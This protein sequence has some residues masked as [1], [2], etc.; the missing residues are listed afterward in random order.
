MPL[1]APDEAWELTLVWGVEGDEK[2]L[3]IEILIFDTYDGTGCS[4][5]GSNLVSGVIL[6]FDP[7]VEGF[8]RTTVDLKGQGLEMEMP[9]TGRIGIR[10]IHWKDRDARIYSSRT[11]LG[12]WYGKS[13]WEEVIGRPD[14]KGF[15]DAEDPN[16]RLDP[17]DCY[18][19][20]SVCPG[21]EYGPIS[22]AIQ[23]LGEGRTTCL[24]KLKKD[25]KPKRG[26]ESCPKKDDLFSNDR[27]CRNGC[28]CAKKAKV[29][30]VDCPEGGPGVCK[31]L[32]GKRDSCGR[33][34]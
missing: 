29:K 26:C 17:N 21:N 20:E 15:N 24:Y 32:K 7:P 31:K 3:E 25:A 6:G 8:Y 27:D 22:Q 33:L 11:S 34:P 5:S 28:H 14:K 12:L 9:D 18:T 2:P 30:K 23:L 10:S 1:R 4:D 13:G 16:C 19:R